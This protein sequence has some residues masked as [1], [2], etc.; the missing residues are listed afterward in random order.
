MAVRAARCE[1]SLS[2]LHGQSGTDFVI[3]AK[4]S[5]YTSYRKSRTSFGDV[6]LLQAR[7][8]DTA[9]SPH[10]HDYYGFALVDAGVEAYF[11]RGVNHLV[12]PAEIVMLNPGDVHTGG[13]YGN[14]GWTY[15][16]LIL[17]P[18]TAGQ[19][20][21]ASLGRSWN[22]LF[23]APVAQDPLVR[24]ALAHVMDAQH[25]WPELVDER[26]AAFFEL[27]MHRQGDA[28]PP[29]AGHAVSDA[30]TDIRDLLLD[31]PLQRRSLDELSAFSSLS[32]TYIVTAFRRR[33]GLPP[34]AFQLHHRLSRARRELLRNRRPIAQIALEN[35]F[36]DQSDLNRHFR[37]FFGISP[38]RMRR[39]I[40]GAGGS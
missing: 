11:A 21:E 30:L 4:T 2:C 13:M 25:L 24:A 23:R 38:A 8:E 33:Y 9:F 35:G 20:A 40:L 29:P 15:R 22:P 36:Y 3:R 34:M 17:E 10:Y 39:H 16:M 37:R 5:E 12:T 26:L 19:L 31:E 18:P 28:R 32:R 7:Y 6:L 1:P 27:A 14:A